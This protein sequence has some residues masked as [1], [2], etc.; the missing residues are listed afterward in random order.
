MLDR[1]VTLT[2]IRTFDLHYS[3][4]TRVPGSVSI[5]NLSTIVLDYG[6]FW[7]YWF[8]LQVGLRQEA[9]GTL[10]VFF[11]GGNFIFPL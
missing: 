7:A 4:Y 10:A 11:L 3:T 8:I 1:D 9:A 6:E 5:H 2:S